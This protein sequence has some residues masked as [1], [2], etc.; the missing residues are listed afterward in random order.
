MPGKKEG[1][2]WGEARAVYLLSGKNEVKVWRRW[3][4][5]LLVDCCGWAIILGSLVWKSVGDRLTETAE[6]GVLVAWTGT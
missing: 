1:R 3:S 2:F 4:G 5:F 6:S